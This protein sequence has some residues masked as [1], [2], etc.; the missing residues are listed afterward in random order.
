MGAP[1]YSIPGST[2]ATPPAAGAAAE[3]ASARTVNEVLAQSQV[4][5]VLDELDRD[6]VGLAPIKQRI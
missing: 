4:E 6:L 3:V 1:N 5:A 2:P